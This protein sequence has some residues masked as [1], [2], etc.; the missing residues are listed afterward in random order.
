LCAASWTERGA[1][2][3]AQSDLKNKTIVPV[4]H[5]DV[6]TAAGRRPAGLLALSVL[7]VALALRLAGPGA[8]PP[9]DDLYHL[10]RISWSAQHVGQVL[11]LDPDRGVGGAWCP[12][13][14]L[15]DL[16]LG[17]VARGIGSD[18]IGWIPPIAFSLFAALL[19]LVIARRHG[20]L[21]GITAG[22]GVALAPYLVA[23]S[24]RGA[25]D[26]HWAEPIAVTAILAA[27]SGC[28]STRRPGLAAVAL[29]AAI[30]A[31]LM[32]QTA[33]L[34]A[35]ALAFGVV[36]LGDR[37]GLHPSFAFGCA[38]LTVC[39]W[40]LSRPAG[41][42]SNVWFLGWPHAAALGAAAVALFLLA[43]GR[44]RVVALLVGGACVLPFLP[45]LLAGAR[46]FGGDSWLTTIVEFQPMLRDR[47][48]IGTDLANLGAAA[49]LLMIGGAAIRARRARREHG[50]FSSRAEPSWFPML[51]PR[52]ASNFHF[53]AVLF[54]VAYLPL[55]LSSR[56]FLVPAIAP[57]VLAAALSLPRN[58]GRANRRPDP[59][60]QS[61]A[62]R[63]PD[64]S[65]QPRADRKPDPASPPVADRRPGPTGQPVEP[66]AN[67]D[68]HPM[69]E[70]KAWPPPLLALRVAAA[71]LVL[72]PALSFDLWALGDREPGPAWMTAPRVLAAEVA[73]LPPGRVL[74]PWS[75]GHA[76]DV[77]GHHA[78]VLD[79]FGSMPD[80]VAFGD[81]TDALLQTHGDV[82]SA[83]CRRNGVRY[84]VLPTAGLR[85][86]A[87]SVGLDPERYSGT[88]LAWRTVWSRLRH[89]ER[90]AGFL[91]RSA[92]V[93]EVED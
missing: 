1:A 81:A 84:L 24:H 25:L 68:P 3:V 29:A 31:G 47:E 14:P 2:N 41:Y 57:L 91:R 16:L 77:L 42:P 5:E 21:P 10:K 18:G 82:L 86:A 66:V 28:R 78:V 50:K 79:N 26:H 9:F 83:W 80:E 35:A 8:T 58:A 60:G 37:V 53:A 46:F 85:A 76:I 61:R 38:A 63:K 34:V 36:F 17:A 12:W 33:L 48:R 54:A 23:V 20:V 73:S 22:A 15:Y 55:A 51:L 65:G 7:A 49:A 88:R 32:M 45:D 92:N 89:G 6:T 56:R 70:A 69:R 64:S 62:D 27:A 74:G 59:R 39:I 4:S 19:A 87:A 11:E 67:R 30:T 13:P 71:L 52:F 93:W 90:L 72:L 40:R 44:R 43:I 75:A